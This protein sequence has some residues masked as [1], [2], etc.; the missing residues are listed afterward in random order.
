MKGF[1]YLQVKYSMQP[2]WKLH[3]MFDD[4]SSRLEGNDECEWIKE[5]KWNV[6]IVIIGLYHWLSQIVIVLPG[7]YGYLMYSFVCFCQTVDSTSKFGD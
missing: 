3:L 1:E 7:F 6:Q 4:I 2:I 5:R